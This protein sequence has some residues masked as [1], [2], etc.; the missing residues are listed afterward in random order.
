MMNSKRFNK[1]IREYIKYLF[2]S[3]DEYP[4]EAWMAEGNEDDFSEYENEF[5]EISYH[6]RYLVDIAKHVVF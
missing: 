4:F 3:D 6:A 1:E 5:A 2:T